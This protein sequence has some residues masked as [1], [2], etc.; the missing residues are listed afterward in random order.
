M[1]QTTGAK[2]GQI[3]PTEDY[4]IY[5]DLK[6]RCFYCG[7]EANKTFN[8]EVAFWAYRQFSVDHIIPKSRMPDRK[9]IEEGLAEITLATHAASWLR[10]IEEF[11]RVPACQSCNII[12]NR[13]ADSQKVNAFLACFSRCSGANPPSE[14]IGGTGTQVKALAHI[15][16]A[17]LDVWKDKQRVLV[18]RLKEKREYY[19]VLYVGKVGMPELRS[20]EYPE[21]RKIVA[22]L[23][24]ALEDRW[25]ALIQEHM[26]QGHEQADS[27]HRR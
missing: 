21:L 2:Q 16:E 19:S 17:I 24:K 27:L 8:A 7:F 25:Q 11:N 12:L 14:V 26:G 4:S 23:R 6:M 22:Q 10:V 13:Y 5:K 9:F 15:M 18:E 1:R 20:R 3:V